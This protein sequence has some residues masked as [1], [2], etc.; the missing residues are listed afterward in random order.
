MSIPDSLQYKI[1][2][3]RSAGRVFR[4]EDE[5]FT[6]PSWV[7]V[8]LGQHITPEAYDPIVSTL[9]HQDVTRS[10]ESMRT[11][12]EAV[13]ARMPTHEEFIARYCAASV[14]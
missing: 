6:R 12:M 2:L 9:P 11:A 7:A 14:Q 10:I 4:F 13:S 3:F 8:F 1:D 5:L